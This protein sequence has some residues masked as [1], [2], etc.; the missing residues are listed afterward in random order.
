MEGEAGDTVMVEMVGWEPPEEELDEPPPQPAR[1]QAKA[2]R[3]RDAARE[4]GASAT[5]ELANMGPP[6]QTESCEMNGK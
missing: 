5:K 1:M 4:P 6:S 3:N 2:R